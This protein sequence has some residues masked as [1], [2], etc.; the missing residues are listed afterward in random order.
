MNEGGET[1]TQLVARIQELFADSKYAEAFQLLVGLEGCTLSEEEQALAQRVRGKIEAIRKL[2]ADLHSDDGWTL[3]REAFGIR[4]LYAHEEGSAL[5][6]TRIEGTIDSPLYNIM[7]VLYEV[8]LYP[9]WVPTYKLLGLKSS[10][11]VMQRSNTQLCCHFVANLP[12]CVRP[13]PPPPPTCRS[14]TTC[15]AC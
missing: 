3:Q 13:P 15:C 2:Q 8:D 5:H 9:R 1:Q 10:E 4:T 6:R 11:K 14:T 7:A 12:W